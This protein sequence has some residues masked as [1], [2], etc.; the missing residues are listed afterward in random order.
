MN[1][2]FILSAGEIRHGD[3]PNTA[4]IAVSSMG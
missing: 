1:P 3:A 4:L 2:Y